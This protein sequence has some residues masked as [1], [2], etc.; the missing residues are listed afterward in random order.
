MVCYN[1]M[2]CLEIWMY[3]YRIYADIMTGICRTCMRVLAAIRHK[4]VVVSATA[5]TGTKAGERTYSYMQVS[6]IMD[7]YGNTI[8]RLAY[9]YV[10]N[11][12]DAEDILQDTLIK[13]MQQAPE[14]ANK[15]HEKAWLLKVAANL[16]KNR[17][18]YNKTRDADEI[19]ENLI[20]EDREDLSFVWE[21]VKE[22]PVNYREA[23][24]LYYYEGYDTKQI[25]HILQKNES[26][27]RSELKRGRD[28]L[29]K[30]LKEA[31]D[32]E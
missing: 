25:S 27:V 16:G 32:F 10:H 31:Y 3:M 14:F 30:I 15:D 2:M 1:R 9:T 18:K 13:Y 7:I 28:R 11:M 20:A 22:L 5:R 19:N 12:D 26:T 29:K 4:G 8:L 23:I 6:N 24:H 17:I 21:A